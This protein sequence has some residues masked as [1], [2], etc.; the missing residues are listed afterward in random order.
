VGSGIAFK[1]AWRFTDPQ[2]N[3]GQQMGAICPDV[4]FPLIQVDGTKFPI[5]LLD[6]KRTILV[7]YE[8]SAGTPYWSTIFRTGVNQY[9]IETG[10][11]DLP[12]A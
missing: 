5:D 6:E 2:R 10:E 3:A 4:S 1:V 11:G 7:T 9:H 8:D 12:S